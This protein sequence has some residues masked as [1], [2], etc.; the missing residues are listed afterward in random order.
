M[1]ASGALLIALAVL[2]LLGALAAWL[3]NFPIWAIGVASLLGAGL[4]WVLGRRLARSRARQ[5]T[6]ARG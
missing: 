3:L 1:S 4:L 6:E 2:G 5:D